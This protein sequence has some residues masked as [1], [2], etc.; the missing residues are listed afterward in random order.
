MN[1]AL[2]LMNSSL[3]TDEFCIKTDEFFIITDK[4]CITND[5]LVRQFLAVRIAIELPISFRIYYWKCRDNVELP[6]KTDWFSI[7][8]WPITLKIGR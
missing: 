3:K 6:L 5:G 4:F 2:K 1:S 7:E 8:D